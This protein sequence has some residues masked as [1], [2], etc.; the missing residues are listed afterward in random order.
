M[1]RSLAILIVSLWISVEACVEWIRSETMLMRAAATWSVERPLSYQFTVRKGC[2]CPELTAT[3]RVDGL[4][5]TRV[6]SPESFERGSLDRFGNIEGIFGAL[7]EVQRR[8]P[9]G[10]RAT[11][12]KELGYPLVAELNPSETISD[13]ES[14][15]QIVDFK[16][17]AK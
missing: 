12:H 3:F 1:S 16:I 14:R 10:M 7:R 4:R 5:S 2:F 11:Y 17:L 6:S 15:L 8:N 13:D 9:T